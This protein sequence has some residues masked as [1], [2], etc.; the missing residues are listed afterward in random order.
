MNSNLTL[1]TCN[2]GGKGYTISKRADGTVWGKECDCVRVRRALKAIE[3]SGLKELLDDYTFDSFQEHER[4]QEDAKET[5]MNY[6]KNS[7]GWFGFFGQVGCGKTHLCTAICG[8]MLRV[9][10]SVRYM[11]WRDDVT[12]LKANV[13]DDEYYSREMRRYKTADVLYIDDLFKT[14]AGKRPTQAD[15]NIAFEILNYRYNNKELMTILSSELQIEDLLA[16]DEAV[17]SRIYERCRKYQVSVKADKRKN[18]R[19]REGK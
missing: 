7:N 12:R 19:L 14:E 16:I 18:Y 2:C 13:M 17:G 3:R 5:A 15:V 11:A 1:S 9:G 6:I 8:E 10:K 4:W